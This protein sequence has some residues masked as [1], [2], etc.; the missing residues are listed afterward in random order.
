MKKISEHIRDFLT[1]KEKLY[2]FNET[3]ENILKKVKRIPETTG[4]WGD[5]NITIRFIGENK[6]IIN[7]IRM[8]FSGSR[9]R[10]SSTLSGGIFEAGKETT[11]IKIK[12]KHSPVLIVLFFI[13]LVCGFG[14]LVKF[15]TDNDSFESLF[16]GLFLIIGGPYFSFWFANLSDIAVQEEFEN[17]LKLK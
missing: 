4:L 15:F 9:G 3:K 16:S 12:I 10:I 1:A 8:N 17:I 6:F 2:S 5:N 11:E 13:T 14:F 7:L